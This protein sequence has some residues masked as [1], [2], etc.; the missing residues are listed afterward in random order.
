MERAAAQ[1]APLVSQEGGSH[2]RGI[3]PVCV[4]VCVCVCVVNM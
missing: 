4:C 2:S 1:P 3:L